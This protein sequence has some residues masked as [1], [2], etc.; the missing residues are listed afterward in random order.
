MIYVDSVC[1]S[2]KVIKGIH[3]Y[4]Y[5][6]YA[7]P[8]NKDELVKFGGKIGLRPEWLRV[9]KS[10]IIHFD[11]TKSKKVMAMQNGAIEMHPIE[12]MKLILKERNNE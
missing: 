5:H 1:V 10:G 7:V 2:K 3:G 9:S 11:I 12:V 6:L 4:W 8:K